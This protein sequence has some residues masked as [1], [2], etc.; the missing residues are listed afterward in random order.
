M[1]PRP[2]GGALISVAY[3]GAPGA[4]SEQAVRRHF[5]AAAATLPC[6]TFAEVAA[7]VLDGSAT[8]GMLPVENTL[9]GTIP[10]VWD[11]LAS[12]PLTVI[13]ERIEPIRHALLG[14]RGAIVPDLRQV[15]S[16]PVAL[17]QCARFFESHR[18]IEAVA[19]YD[20]AGAAEEVAS[21]GDGKV[22]ALA[23]AEAAP[24]HG[25][26]VLA[27]DLQDREDNQTRFY[28]VARE[29]RPPA[30]PEGPARM[31]CVVDAAN[32]PGALLALLE[33]LARHG[34]NLSLVVSLPTGEPWT[35]RFII[36][37]EVHG[38]E[39][40]PAIAE[41]ALHAR[42]VRQLGPFPRATAGGNR[43]PFAPA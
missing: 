1:P 16:H 29:G 38:D 3:Q 8:H 30:L 42:T 2:A 5:G 33:P 31:T 32:R 22:A 37:C 11:L 40:G 35:Y 28:V 15:L 23:S 19:W 43:L 36:E 34:V 26:E 20:T 9:A 4:F 25:L 14:L 21:R 6:R 12:H 18:A 10:A 24:R 17:A 27:A 13:G 39:A 41:L 7:A